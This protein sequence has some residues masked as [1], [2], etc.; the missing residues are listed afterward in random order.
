ME[1]RRI[2]FVGTRFA[3]TDGVS[4]ETKKWAHVLEAEG[5]ECFYM[6]GELDVANG[7]AMQ[8]PECFFEEAGVLE[9]AR[10]CFG[11]ATRDPRITLQVEEI[12]HR[13]KQALNE[14]VSKFSLDLLIPENAV[15]IPLNI[16]LGLAIAEFAIE[17]GQ[18]MIAHNHDFF[19][20]R[21]RFMDNC[22]WDYLDKAFPPRL[23]TIQ[24]VVLNSS[25]QHQ[26]GRRKGISATI[27]PNV[28]DYANPPPPPDT[29]AD[30]MRANLGIAPD[31]KFILQPTRIV[32]RKGI[33]HAIELV[34]R[35]GIPAKLVISH[36]CGDEGYEYYQRVL[37]YSDMMGVQTVLCSDNVGEERG[38]TEDGRKI[39][40]LADMYR[41]A[42]FVTYPSVLEGFGNA[43]LESVYYRRPLLVN[44][45]SI[46]SY[47]I[48]PKGFM[49]VE[50]DGY[51]NKETVRATL[52]ILENPDIVREMTEHNYDLANRFFSYDVLCHNLRALMVRCFGGACADTRS[53]RTRH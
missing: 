30:D 13:L 42:D 3:G 52:E 44:N 39:Y 31:E 33:E 1:K 4:L 43:F 12:K 36:A 24:H 20:E 9:T 2:G 28:M 26:I 19:W 16:P 18:V 23:S 11:H 40:T 47:D 45:Y 50:M 51:V 38:V 53:I 32:Q 48:K 22:C 25:Q 34:H 21:K 5:H 7:N 35:L 49:T 17:S 14:F 27:I 10:G 41:Q 29:Y 46:Y 15:T 8:V 6:A 37:D